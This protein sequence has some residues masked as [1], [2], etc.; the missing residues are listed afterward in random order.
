MVLILRICKNVIWMGYHVDIDKNLEFTVFGSTCVMILPISLEDKRVSDKGTREVQHGLYIHLPGL[1]GCSPWQVC[2]I[3]LVASTEANPVFPS[4][5]LYFFLLIFFWFFGR[6]SLTLLIEV[7]LCYWDI[8][9]L[10]CI[11]H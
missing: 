2:R 9:H 4:I 6:S 10:T 3:F 11:N 8:F 5:F 7:V 1:W